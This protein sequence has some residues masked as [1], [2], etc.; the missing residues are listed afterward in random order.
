LQNFINFI[1]S[2]EDAIDYPER[3]HKKRKKR[4]RKRP[5][6]RASSSSSVAHT[7]AGSSESSSHTP[8]GESTPSAHLN[9]PISQ[10]GTI[11]LLTEI[12]STYFLLHH[13]DRILMV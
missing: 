12:S 8:A 1:D 3:G 10:N 5:Q 6:K 13:L 11:E 4:R 7:D 2:L 9:S